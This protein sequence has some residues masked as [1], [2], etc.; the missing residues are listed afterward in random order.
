MPMFNRNHSWLLQSLKASKSKPRL[1]LLKIFDLTL[2]SSRPLPEIEQELLRQQDSLAR[3][4][5]KQAKACGAQL[6]EVLAQQILIMLE[7]A[8]K[9]ELRYPGSQALRQA[10]TASDALI[11][12]QCDHSWRRLRDFGMSASFISLLGI[13]LFMSWYM[14][15]ETPPMHKSPSSHQLWNTVAQEAVVA[16]PHHVAE[17]YSAIERM[18]QGNCHFPQALMLSAPE[19]GVFLTNI[20]AGN[21]SSQAEEI[22]LASQLL[23]KVSCEYKPLTMLSESE[24]AYIK[25]RLTVPAVTANKPIQRS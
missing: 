19:R 15:R 7:N 17:L 25:A 3:Y 16:S 5:S 22:T 13:T 11:H 6:P 14:L 12:A 9:E 2:M 1:R 24:Q 23:N 8:L 18:R 20:V 10:R 4:L 21:I